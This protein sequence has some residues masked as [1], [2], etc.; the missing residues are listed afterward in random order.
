M[1]I[2]RNEIVDGQLIVRHGGYVRRKSDDKILSF[3]SYYPN[4][5]C[6][7]VLEQGTVDTKDGFFESL[8]NIRVLA[9]HECPNYHRRSEF[10]H[11]YAKSEPKQS[12]ADFVKERCPESVSEATRTSAAEKILF[13]N[14]IKLRR[15][16]APCSNLLDIRN[17]HNEN[18]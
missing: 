14:G 1:I 4:M 13:S 6:V 15:V 9:P 12:L 2:P 7:Y 18:K 8:D 11:D 3:H 17:R 16:K 10:T 5:N